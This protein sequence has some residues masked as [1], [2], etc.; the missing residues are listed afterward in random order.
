MSDIQP[1]IPSAESPKEEFQ[2]EASIKI[3]RR[4]DW[5]KF[6]IFLGVISLIIAG[7]GVF[8]FLNSYD[9]NKGESIIVIISGIVSSIQSF[10]ISFLINV[11]TDIRWFLKELVE[12]NKSN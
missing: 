9:G 12:K 11:F 5:C 8:M 4:S 7:I 6:F 3:Y 1:Y 2:P 10:F